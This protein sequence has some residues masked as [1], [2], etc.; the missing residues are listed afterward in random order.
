[1]KLQERA[2]PYPLLLPRASTTRE[3]RIRHDFRGEKGS[4][5][6]PTH[7]FFRKKS[8]V[9]CDPTYCASGQCIKYPK[10]LQTQI[11]SFFV[12][13]SF[14]PL[15]LVPYVLYV[16][17]LLFRRK[18]RKFHD[19]CPQS[20]DLHVCMFMIEF[21][22]GKVEHDTVVRDDCWNGAKP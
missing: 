13:D 22:S 12:I 19:A 17:V 7:V 9:A 10:Y 11:E 2:Q 14:Q 16:Y 21:V 15:V 18:S 8:Y 20:L 4:L 1:M 5:R 3:S 6:V